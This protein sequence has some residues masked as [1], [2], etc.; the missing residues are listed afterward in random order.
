LLTRLWA[1]TDQWIYLAAKEAYES[2]LSQLRTDSQAQFST[3]WL[4]R[5]VLKTQLYSTGLLSVTDGSLKG[6][7]QDLLLTYIAGELIPANLKRAKTKGLVRT[8]QMQKNI[9]KLLESVKTNQKEKSSPLE[10][11]AKFNKKM[12]LD[13]PSENDLAAAKKEYLQDVADSMEKDADGPRLFLGALSN[14]FASKHEGVLY[15]TGKFAPRLLKSLKDELSAEQV[16]RLEEIKEA[17]K[18]GTMDDVMREELR[19]LGKAAVEAH[20]TIPTDSK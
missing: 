7:L 11:L 10:A 8:P 13:E 14:I 2:R 12:G 6:Q 19:V 17:V 9:T 18:A 15:A 20:E 5:V 1:R 3:L 16:K 4:T